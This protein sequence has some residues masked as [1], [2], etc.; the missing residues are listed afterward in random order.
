M[1]PGAKPFVDA[2]A[3][4]VHR[5][6]RR[7]ADLEMIS[8]LYFPLSGDQCAGLRSTKYGF[9]GKSFLAFTLSITQSGI[10]IFTRVLLFK[11]ASSS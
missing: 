5:R 1:R 4:Y 10:T 2:I 3:V 11:M 6:I 8:Q 9:S 7:T